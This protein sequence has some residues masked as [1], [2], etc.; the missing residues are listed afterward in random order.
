VQVYWYS[1]CMGVGGAFGRDFHSTCDEP[2][3]RL[4]TSRTRTTALIHE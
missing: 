1:F 3:F 2:D 4:L